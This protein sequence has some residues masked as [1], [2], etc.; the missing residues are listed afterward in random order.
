[1]SKIPA[2]TKAALRAFVG[3]G[4]NSKARISGLYLY[5]D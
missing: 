4:N 1:M 2:P 3:A 5:N